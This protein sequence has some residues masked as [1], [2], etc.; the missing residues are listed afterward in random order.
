[1]WKPDAEAIR[2]DV[3]LAA[4][5]RARGEKW[6]WRCARRRELLQWPECPECERA[7]LN[8]GPKLTRKE[9]RAVKRRQIQEV[10]EEQQ[11]AIIDRVRERRA[12]DVGASTGAREG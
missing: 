2:R 10:K 7:R 4:A 12:H 9:A 3:E 8:P 1:M 11:R 5:A 6:C